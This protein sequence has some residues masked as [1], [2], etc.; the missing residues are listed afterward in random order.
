MEPSVQEKFLALM[1]EEGNS[2]GEM[3]MMKVV[4]MNLHFPQFVFLVH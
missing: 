4:T 2:G 3:Q 1:T